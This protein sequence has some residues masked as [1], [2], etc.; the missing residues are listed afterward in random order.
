MLTAHWVAAGIASDAKNGVS[1]S[2]FPKYALG[3]SPGHTPSI[4]DDIL[5]NL[6]PFATDIAD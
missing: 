2:R 4:T 3:K 5:T 1:I 6:L